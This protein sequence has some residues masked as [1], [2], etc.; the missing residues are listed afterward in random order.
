MQ[1]GVFPH[2][3]RNFPQKFW[4]DFIKISK[5]KGLPVPIIENYIIPFAFDRN[6]RWLCFDILNP[7]EQF[8][9]FSW[10]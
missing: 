4:K 7:C 9:V 6:Y 2:N 10:F 1:Y 3:F 5:F 8:L